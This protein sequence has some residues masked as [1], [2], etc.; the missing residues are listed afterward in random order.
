MVLTDRLIAAEL[1]PH[2]P[3]PYGNRIDF[4]ARLASQARWGCAQTNS[5][6]NCACCRRALV[7]ERIG[8]T[9]ATAITRTGFGS[10]H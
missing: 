8:G 9:A 2:G 6:T 1:P 5:A 7:I 4:S 10:G 3:A